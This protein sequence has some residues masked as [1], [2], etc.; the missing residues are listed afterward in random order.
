MVSRR[1]PGS[2]IEKGILPRESGRRRCSS[3]PL[4]GEDL[5]GHHSPDREV[6]VAVRS[7]L[8]EPVDH[9]TPDRDH[10]ARDVPCQVVGI[11]EGAVGR[12]M[13]SEQVVSVGPR[14]PIRELQ[15]VESV[16]EAKSLHHGLRPNEHGRVSMAGLLASREPDAETEV[17][18]PEK[19]LSVVTA[20]EVDV[21]EGHGSLGH[22]LE[23]PP[24]HGDHIRQC[25][26]E[27]RV[28]EQQACFR[29]PTC[30]CQQDGQCL[31]DGLLGVGSLRP[32]LLQF[33]A[34]KGTGLLDV[35][36]VLREVGGDLIPFVEQGRDGLVEHEGLPP[37][38][39]TRTTTL[40]TWV[41]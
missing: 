32:P 35:R 14:Q 33:F 19:G 38:S 9:L 37:R 12:A 15:C 7:H 39:I 5:R 25:P 18:E 10:V 1:F 30:G 26:N 31:V 40:V 8:D 4:I 22:R 34:G 36:V 16:A 11:V 6:I 17:F 28:R 27:A 13:D 21:I 41:G 24:G 20:T 29:D 2:N 23:T 3:P